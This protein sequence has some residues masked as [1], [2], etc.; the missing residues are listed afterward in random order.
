MNSCIVNAEWQPDPA[1]AS[2]LVIPTWVLSF[3]CT[4]KGEKNGG[5]CYGGG[6]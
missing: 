6:W 2:E 5:G 1:S 4:K 3:C